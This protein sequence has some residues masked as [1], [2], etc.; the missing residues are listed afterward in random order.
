MPGGRFAGE[1]FAYAYV[2][3]PF[4][5]ITSD[6][7][8][9]GIDQ[10][11]TVVAHELGHIFGALD[12]YASAGT[13]CTQRSGYLSV[14]TTNSQAG[15]CGTHEPSIMLEPLTAFVRGD[16]DRSALGQL[17]Y[18]DGDGDSIP[19]P[20]DT[21]PAI[22]AQIS[23]PAAGQTPCTVGIAAPVDART[24]RRRRSRLEIDNRW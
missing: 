12:Q 21:A 24:L 18:R 1:H 23:Q 8:P 14:P 7:G 20:L 2:N 11:D 17:G 13:P 10:M 22:Q 19:D 3:G 6:A 5:V 4:M 16:I 9:Y 15:S